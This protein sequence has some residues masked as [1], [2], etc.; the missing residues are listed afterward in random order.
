MTTP[1]TT[2]TSA[3]DAGVISIDAAPAP[4]PEPEIG[5]LKGST[6][7]H[8]KPSGDSS[9]EPADVIRWY[10]DHGYDFIVL[11][12]HN[13]VTPVEDLPRR[14]LVVIPGVELT[15]NSNDCLEPPPPEQEKK[16]RI[17]VNAIGV[18]A[19]PEGK[20]PWDEH[21][22]RVRLGTYALA[23]DEAK[24]LGG[25]AQINHPQWHWGMT[26]E[27]LTE[28][29]KRGAPL[30]EVWNVQFATWNAGDA[31]HLST[32]ALWDAVLAQG[33]DLW[34]TASDD[35]HDYRG[36]GPYPP[37]GAWV[38]VHAARDARSIVDALA[39]GRFYASSGVTL[40]HAEVEGD[41]LVVAIAD[42][43]PGPHTIRFVAGGHVLREVHDR[44][45]RF[46]L[47]DLA[48]APGYVRAVVTRDADG[49]H[50]WVQPA[51][52]R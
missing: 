1:T 49:A 19:R 6:H 24:A 16:C 38:M 34:G 37:G 15:H 27:L 51:R 23:L 21:A 46:A 14:T 28:L 17:H 42:S 29:A 22:T 43:D 47:A 32:E 11:S 39:A 10:E 52:R 25:V 7:V 3:P 41:A 20:I 33:I 44:S 31:D 45:A 30:F 26:P 12:D 13:R 35:A 5:W 50:A 48:A 8:A 18:S 4:E 36:V 40:S 9:E 2:T